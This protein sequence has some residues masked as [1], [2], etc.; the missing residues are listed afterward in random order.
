MS[1]ITTIA[2]NEGIVMTGDRLCVRTPSGLSILQSQIIS[3][4]YRKLFNIGNIGIS[5]VSSIQINSDID[6]NSFCRINNFNSVKET[7]DS[8]IYYIQH[9]KDEYVF[10][11]SGYNNDKPEV[12]RISTLK[13]DLI[14]N[15]M[16]FNNKLK[17]FNDKCF[18][19]QGSSPYSKEYVDI[20]NS[21]PE[22]LDLYTL[23]DAVNVSKLIFD[24][25][26]GLDWYL[27][28]AE[29]MAD[30]EMLAITPNGLKYLI[31]KELEVLC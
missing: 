24:I 26:K 23:Q 17:S 3:R 5:C 16:G 9:S 13:E 28:H 27:H 1:H 29:L 19:H 21:K 25:G 14:I 7:A 31:K 30:L 12:Y 6:I 22:L 11:V 2:V 18:I 8:L 20:I 15:K 10:H 4:S